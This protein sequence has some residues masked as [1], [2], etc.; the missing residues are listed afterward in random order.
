M[1][2][3]IKRGMIILSFGLIGS[4]TSAFDLFEGHCVIASP[5]IYGVDKGTLWENNCYLE[6]IN[7]GEFKVRFYGNV[8]LRSRL[9]LKQ[10][11]LNRIVISGSASAGMANV[12][13]MGGGSLIENN[14]VYGTL[15]SERRNIPFE[16]IVRT[17]E[18]YLRPASEQEVFATILAHMNDKEH[19]N[20][21]KDVYEHLYKGEKESADPS[22]LALDT[23]LKRDFFSDISEKLRF[24]KNHIENIIRSGVITDQH[25]NSDKPMFFFTDPQ[26]IEKLSTQSTE[27][28]ISPKVET[29]YNPMT[30]DELT[31]M[32]V[33]EANMPDEDIEKLRKNLE[34]E[35]A[36]LA[37]KRRA[38]QEP[39]ISAEVQT[40]KINIPLVLG[41]IVILIIFLIIRSIRK[42]R[43]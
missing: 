4:N 9:I 29:E 2:R 3:F 24:E 12:N 16:V 1:T 31:E 20:Y 15:S 13:V 18:W 26:F 37:N 23:R 19:Y 36:V 34:Q 27:V 22:L 10:V 21:K 28:P 42:K 8:A 6:K 41:G 33:I 7:D 32:G 5:A 17:G 38:K 35:Q 14:T 39:P 11:S 30:I 40:M 43:N 25:E